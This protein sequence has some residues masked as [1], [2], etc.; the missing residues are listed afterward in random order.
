[1]HFEQLLPLKPPLESPIATDL[2]KAIEKA[3]H[4]RD[5]N[6]LVTTIMLAGAT[7]RPAYREAGLITY[8]FSPFKVEIADAQKG[9]HGNDE[10]LSVENVGFGVKLLYDV[11]LNVQ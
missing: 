8:G 9:V 10:R 6:A 7:D 5:P 2:Y 3:A 11:I 1:V 4:A